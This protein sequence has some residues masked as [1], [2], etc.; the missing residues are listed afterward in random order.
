MGNS[1]ISQPSS[2]PM[3]PWSWSSNQHRRLNPVRWLPL[4]C[5]PW[6]PGQCGVCPCSKAS[7]QPLPHVARDHR[8][9]EQP[10][11]C[12]LPSATRVRA[13]QAWTGSS[14]NLGFN[15]QSLRPKYRKRFF[16]G[17]LAISGRTSTT[18]CQVGLA[19]FQDPTVTMGNLSEAQ[20]VL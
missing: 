19:E 1:K 9:Q 2:I 14:K 13:R 6:Y 17:H 7:R 11:I 4:T 20:L 3:Q 10:H 5:H 12:P 18:K 15:R 8:R 16:Q